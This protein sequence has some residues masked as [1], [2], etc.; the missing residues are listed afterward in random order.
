MDNPLGRITTPDFL[1]PISGGDVGGLQVILNIVLRTLIMG[2]G[3]YAVINILLA[4]YAFMSASG[5]PKR[6]SDATAK[7][8]HTA[9]GFIIAAGAFV[10]AGVLGQILF[11]D[12]NAILQLKYFSAVPN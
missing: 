12:F 3:I 11:G 7:I 10:I 8:W 2:A 9:L 1:V 4:G 6:I 5:D